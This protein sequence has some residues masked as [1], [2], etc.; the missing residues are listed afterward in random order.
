[1]SFGLQNAGATYQRLVDGVFRDQIGRNMEVY[2]DDM[3]MSSREVPDLVE[4]LKETLDTLRPTGRLKSLIGLSRKVP[5]LSHPQTY[6]QAEV[7]NREVKSILEKT[8]NARLNRRGENWHASVKASARSIPPRS[9]S[10]SGSNLMKLSLSP[11]S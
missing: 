9:Q 1:M 10:T 2:V 7:S 5:F 11:K 8:V 4:N 3:V 6:G